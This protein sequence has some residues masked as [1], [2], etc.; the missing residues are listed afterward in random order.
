MAGPFDDDLTE[1]EKKLLEQHDSVPPAADEDTDPGNSVAAAVEEAGQKPADEKPADQQPPEQQTQ[2]QGE[3]DQQQQQQAPEQTE[4]QELAAFL[5]KHKGKSPEELARLAFQQQK[6]ANREAATNRTTREAV[7]QLAE[8]ARQAAERRQQVGTDIE[9][10]KAAFREK[11]A[12]DPDAAVAELFDGIA[13]GQLQQADAAVVQARQDAAIA[14]ADEHIPDFG[15]RWPEMHGLAK[16]IGFTDAELD[17]IDD[18]RPLVMLSLAAMTAR[19]M[20]AGVMDRFGNIVNAAAVTTTPVDPRL[21]A[22]DP[23]GTLGNGRGA[24]TNPSTADQLN[25]LLAMS[26]EEFAKVDPKVIEDLMRKAA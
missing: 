6:R 19:L 22:P 9:A 17:Q 20:K 8:R 14:F 10:K 5:E 1:D 21:A 16:E 25:E 26:E 15:K 2:Q 18:G 23:Q 11:L 13:D 24:K 3:T 4:E 12:S 7:N